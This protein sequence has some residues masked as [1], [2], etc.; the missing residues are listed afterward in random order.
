M[1]TGVVQQDGVVGL[2]LTS[3]GP[4]LP[5]GAIQ[6]QPL[7]SLNVS[8]QVVIEPNNVG[9]GGGTSGGARETSV[10]F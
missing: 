10:V 9:S 1:A 5:L 3:K 4:A 7:L 2:G 6:T 8:R